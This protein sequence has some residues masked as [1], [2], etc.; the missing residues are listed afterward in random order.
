MAEFALNYRRVMGRLIAGPRPRLGFLALVAVLLLAAVALV[1]A[2]LVAAV[3]GF[4]LL[5]LG[6]AD[7]VI[8]NAGVV[9]DVANALAGPMTIG[10]F[11]VHDCLEVAIQRCTAASQYG[12]CGSAL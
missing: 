2:G 3:G 8:E 1:G 10:V 4:W 12:Y 5:F 11:G 9:V 7:H 6:G